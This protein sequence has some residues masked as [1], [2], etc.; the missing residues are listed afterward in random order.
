MCNRIDKTQSLTCKYSSTGTYT[1]SLWEAT[2]Q[3]FLT[4]SVR[5]LI[6]SHTVQNIPAILQ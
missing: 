4:F 1:L 2:D 3:L 5:Q 6:I